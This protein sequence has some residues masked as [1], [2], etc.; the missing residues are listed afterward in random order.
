ML[1]NFKAAMDDCTVHGSHVLHLAIGVQ[2]VQKLLTQTKEDIQA[3]QDKID[4]EHKESK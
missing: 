1:Q 4:S 2:F 3:I